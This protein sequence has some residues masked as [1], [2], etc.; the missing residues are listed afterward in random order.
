MN[1]PESTSDNH[2]SE[3]P[4]NSYPDVISYLY[5]RLPMFSRQGADAIKA[6]LINT[7]K[8]CSHLFE[9][10]NKFKS[11][12]IGGTNGK[13]STSHMLAAILQTAG[14][15]T[16][17]YTSPH[18]KDFRE[19][20]RINGEMISEQEVL[21]FVNENHE[22]I[23]KI[24]PSFFEVTVAMAFQ[25]FAVNEV[26][27]AIIEVGLG[28]RLDST[29]VIHPVLSLISNIAFDHVNILGSTLPL[30]A[31]EKAGIIKK[32]VPVI[33]SQKQDEVIDVFIKKAAEQ[34]SK[35]V[36]ASDEWSIK[37]SS[38]QQNL[39]EFL[40]VD[41][42][43]KNNTIPP[44][45][46]FPAIELDLTGTYQL[47][48]LGGVLSAVKQLRELDYQISDQDITVALRQVKAL[49]G[50][51]GRWQMLQETPLVI[52]D[53]GHN[54]DGIREVL[55]NIEQSSFD[56]LHIVIGMLRD[57]DSSGILKMLPQNAVYYFCQPDLPRAKQAIELRD[58]AKAHN[59]QGEYYPSVCDALDAAKESAGKK[60]LIFVGGSTFVVAEVV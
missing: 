38:S 44:L 53:T 5:S 52:C 12:H 33:I 14:Y 35:I 22:F 43:Q 28:G 41:I 49:T 30:I 60:D 18:L 27:I 1:M 10:Q 51:M 20:I 55:K 59:L 32:S 25:H 23:E 7:Q 54:E 19:R 9:P 11:V 24:E 16:G 34:Q 57:K 26:D 58:E 17:L 6:D 8:F 2:K 29:N 31:G 45:F 36:F 21:Q 37:R 42:S 48:N 4:F 40:K 15:K 56:R 13:G 39:P 46:S 47:K 3:N 50:L